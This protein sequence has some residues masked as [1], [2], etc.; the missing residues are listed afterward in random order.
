[1]RVDR[2]L[3]AVDDVE[4]AG[5][6]ARLEEELGEAHRHARIALGRLQD[7]GV[8]AGDRRRELPQ[9]DHGGEVER[10]DAGDDARAAGASSRCR[11]RGRR[12]RC[13][14]PSA[15]A[16]CRR[17]IPPPRCR[18]GCR[19]WRPAMVLPCS[20]ASSSARS[21]SSLGDE[22]EELHHHAGAAL[23]IGAPPSRAAPP[24]RSRPR[25]RSS[26]LLASATRACTSPVIGLEDV[27]EAAG[28]ARP[29]ACRR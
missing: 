26:A 28:R 23:R 7:E 14:R 18:A 5:R 8:A 19:P 29:R 27:G 16:G 12:L 22:F 10:R 24:W 21:S 3:V 17:R 25:A 11:C 13:T 1:M 2:L 6:Q 9:R 20:R 15:G 4:D